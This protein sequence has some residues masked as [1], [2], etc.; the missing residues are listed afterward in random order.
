MRA[1]RPGERL[2]TLDGVERT[3]EPEALV[4]ADRDRAVALAGI[5]GG[6][7]TE[8][9]SATRRVLALQQATSMVSTAAAR[10]RR[11]G[12]GTTTRSIRT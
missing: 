1:A 9:T 8:V 10:P 7:E 4:I 12:R 2:V 6:Q 5:M 3:L 11:G